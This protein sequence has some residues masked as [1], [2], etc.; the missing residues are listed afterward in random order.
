MLG[1]ELSGVEDKVMVNPLVGARDSIIPG[2][3]DH[4]S[5]TKVGETKTL[6]LVRVFRM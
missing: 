2:E 4:H 1:Q 6:I 5:L 3:I